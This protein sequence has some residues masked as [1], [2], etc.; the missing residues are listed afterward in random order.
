MLRY[1]IQKKVDGELKLWYGFKS[2]EDAVR[3]RDLL[4]RVGWDDDKL[5]ELDEAEGTL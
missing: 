1:Y 3:E 5:M 2:V 4:I